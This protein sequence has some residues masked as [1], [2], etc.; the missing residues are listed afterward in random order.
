MLNAGLSDLPRGGVN[1][2]KPGRRAESASPMFVRRL[3][4]ALPPAGLDGCF[5]DEPGLMPI[6][7]SVSEEPR[8][9]RRR[10]DENG[11]ATCFRAGLDAPGSE[12]R[13]RASPGSPGKGLRN[14]WILRGDPLNLIRVMPAKGENWAAKGPLFIRR[15]ARP[16]SLEPFECSCS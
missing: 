15:P 1:A 9:K 7:G 10:Q 16:G 3:A 11:P 2:L 4:Q 5:R 14:R 12:R 13:L 6:G 8:Q